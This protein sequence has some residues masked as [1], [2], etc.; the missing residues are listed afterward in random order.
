MKEKNIV[1][2]V[3]CLRCFFSWVPRKNPKEIIC[4]PNCKSR[5]FRIPKRTKNDTLPTPPTS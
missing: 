4:C 1:I 3:N 5:L 2:K